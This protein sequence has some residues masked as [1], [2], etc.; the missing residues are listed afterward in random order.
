[1]ALGESVKS[2][3]TSLQHVPNYDLKKGEAKK[4]DRFY[5]DFKRI[6]NNIREGSFFNIAIDR[7]N[8]ALEKKK[9]LTR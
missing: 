8:S 6:S 1:M 9:L 5:T 2:R 4:F 3:P 7:F